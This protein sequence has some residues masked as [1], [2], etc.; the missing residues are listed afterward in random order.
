MV[1]FIHHIYLIEVLELLKC[2]C[3]WIFNLLIIMLVNFL[4]W[5][6]QHLWLVEFEIMVAVDETRG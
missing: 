6:G 2:R 5:D 3:C 4:L 1:E